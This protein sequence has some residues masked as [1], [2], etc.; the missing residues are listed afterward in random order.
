MHYRRAL[1]SIEDDELEEVAGSIGADDQVAGGILSNL[2]DDDGVSQDVLDVL[3]TDSVAKRRPEN[4]H[5]GIVLQNVPRGR[6]RQLAQ[7]TS[8]TAAR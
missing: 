3:G 5:P 2:F 8:S 1:G 7:A 6:G 4:L